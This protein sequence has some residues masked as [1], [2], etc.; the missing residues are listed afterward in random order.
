MIGHFALAFIFLASSVVLAK[1]A[2]S[3]AAADSFYLW[4]MSSAVAWMISYR[5]GDGFL[6]DL[7]ELI[8]K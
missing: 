6:D 8:C 7:K 3:R 1:K 2:R 5:L 4:L